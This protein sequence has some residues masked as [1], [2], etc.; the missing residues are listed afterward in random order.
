MKP[1]SP[2]LVLGLGW[3]VVSKPF[4]KDTAR[5]VD[6]RG[7]QLASRFINFANQDMLTESKKRVALVM[8][9]T[10]RQLTNKFISDLKEEY[11][12]ED[13]EAAG[14]DVK[15]KIE[16]LVLSL[17]F[18]KEFQCTEGGGAMFDESSLGDA[19]A[20]ILNKLNAAAGADGNTQPCLRQR[21]RN[22]TNNH[23][24]PKFFLIKYK[25]HTSFNF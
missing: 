14:K 16:G 25:S 3:L 23:R 18:E 21:S 7:L 24:M 4:H 8:V 22:G 1:L 19:E 17:G 2:L 15:R 10:M 20:D 9:G 11:P 5:D 6:T 12:E 13:L